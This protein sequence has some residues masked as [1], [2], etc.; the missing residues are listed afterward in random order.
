MTNHCGAQA[1]RGPQL[2]WTNGFL[3]G[4][5]LWSLTTWLT[6][7]PWRFMHKTSRWR[8]ASL[9]HV[10]LHWEF[11]EVENRKICHVCVNWISIVRQFYYFIARL[12]FCCARNLYDIP[13]IRHSL[14]YP[15]YLC[16]CNN[17]SALFDVMESKGGKRELVAAYRWMNQN[18]QQRFNSFV[19]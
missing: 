4:S 1:G 6:R 5:Q 17:T 16:K 10:A 11:I 19:S 2:C 12:S 9:P 8:V 18:N 13:L 7:L 14:I 3:S 15:Y